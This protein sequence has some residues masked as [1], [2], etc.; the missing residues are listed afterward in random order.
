MVVLDVPFNVPLSGPELFKQFIQ[1]NLGGL[2]SNGLLCDIHKLRF[3][4]YL[5]NPSSLLIS[6]TKVSIDRL[7]SAWMNRI[8]KAPD[9]CKVLTFGKSNA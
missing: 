7:T 3:F 2:V 8:L 1:V 4:G 6:G 5:E 9:Y